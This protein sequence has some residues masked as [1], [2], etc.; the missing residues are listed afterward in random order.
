VNR[1]IVIAVTALLLLPA[2]ADACMCA[3]SPEA[4]TTA[5]IT[6]EVKAAV[7]KA[8]AVFSGRAIGADPMSVTFLVDNVWKGRAT[9]VFMMS[10]GA[11]DNGDGTLTVSSCD[12]SFHEGRSYVVFAHPGRDGGALQ[13]YSCEFTADLK[14]AP[15][16]PGY[17]DRVAERK[18]LSPPGRR[19][20]LSPLDT[21]AS[22]P[23]GEVVFADA[24]SGERHDLGNDVGVARTQVVAVEAEERRDGQEA[25]PFV[26]IAVGVVPHQAES[27]RRGQRRDVDG[28]GVAPFLLRPCQ[29]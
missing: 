25:D 5:Q 6:A 24:S 16:T 10:T 20:A 3:A 7:E 15:D 26:A 14:D 22:N 4:K 12:F 19:P 23:V 27:V 29:R 1:T 11:V 8:A 21:V 28:L 17:L 9:R 2:A 13:A 18:V